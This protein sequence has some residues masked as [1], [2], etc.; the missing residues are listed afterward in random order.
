MR[1]LNASTPST[2]RA[3]T[4][5]HRRHSASRS[6]RRCGQANGATI[7]SAPP[8]RSSVNSEGGTNAAAARPLT[9]LPAQNNIDNAS[10]NGP[11]AQKRAIAGFGLTSLTRATPA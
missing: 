10:N 7:T 4:T 6:A 8:H 11:L 9:M 5:G 1:L 2:A 3:T